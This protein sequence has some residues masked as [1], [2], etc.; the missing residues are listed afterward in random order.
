[1]M[2]VK[3]PNGVVRECTAPTEQKVFKTASD[4]SG[5]ILQLRLMGEI[6]SSELDNLVTVGNTTPL[7]FL[8][9][10]DSGED[11][12]IFTLDGYEKITSSTI[13]HAENTISTSVEIQLTKGL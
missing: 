6:T 2:K 10:T 1:M 12:T 5:W 9:E 3:F 13:R 11:K 7:V 4:E 8:T